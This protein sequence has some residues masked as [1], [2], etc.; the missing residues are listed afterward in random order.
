LNQT[1]AFAEIIVVDDLSTDDT[2]EV[3]QTYG[4]QITLYSGNKMGVQ[5]ARNFGVAQASTEY[6][7]LCD[8]DD[9]LSPTYVETMCRYLVQ[10]RDIDSVYCNFQTFTD[11]GRDA[12]KFDQSPMNW[13]LGGHV[14]GYR[15]AFLR[16]I[17]DLYLRTVKFQPLFPTGATFRKSYYQ[18]IGGFDSRMNGI[19]GEDW[20][21]T[22]RAILYGKTAVCVEVM[23]FIRKHAGN[24]SASAPYM[25]YGECQ[26]LNYALEHHPIPPRYKEAMAASRDKRM[27]AA[28]DGYFALGDYAQARKILREMQSKPTAWKFRLKALLLTMP[29]FMVPPSLLTKVTS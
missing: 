18:D 20:E 29:R 22:L 19:G 15:L 25:N 14:G 28:F 17:P 26:I 24:D 23:S 8:S 5:A 4:D 12:P 10:Q 13:F 6:I 11:K 27:V 9:L 3:L 16:D 2:V 7:T 21:F 1:V